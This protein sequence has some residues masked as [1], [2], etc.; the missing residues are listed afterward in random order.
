[1]ILAKQ[2]LLNEEYRTPFI[3]FLEFWWSD[4]AI[5]VRP[6]HSDP[7]VLE[8]NILGKGSVACVGLTFSHV[9]RDCIK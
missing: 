9:S 7:V 8:T 3:A 5:L 2:R 4:S 1:M 6:G